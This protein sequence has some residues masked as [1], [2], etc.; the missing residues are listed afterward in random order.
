MRNTDLSSG[1]I[2]HDI[3]ES[4][5]EDQ[6]RE[7][8][9]KKEDIL[10]IIKDKSDSELFNIMKSRLDYLREYIDFKPK[11]DKEEVLRSDMPSLVTQNYFDN[12]WDELVLEGNKGIKGAI[13]KHIIDVENLRMGIY[14]DEAGELG[15]SIEEYKQELQ[16]CVEK[17]VS[18]CELFRA[19]HTDPSSNA[20]GIDVLDAVFNKDGRF[21][22]L[23]EVNDSDGS[24]IPW[25]LS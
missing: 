13:K 14:R 1:R 4:D 10:D 5:I 25:W 18:N 2:F 17:L 22:S 3:T 8:L 9:R 19:T 15:M 21:K 12:G 20:V 11:K 16:S 24:N 6:I 23:F 7:I